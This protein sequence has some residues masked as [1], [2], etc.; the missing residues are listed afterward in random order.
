[1][2]LL[3]IGY[4]MSKDGFRHIWWIKHFNIIWFVSFVHIWSALSILELTSWWCSRYLTTYFGNS[5]CILD[6]LYG[7]CTLLLIE[8]SHWI[9]L[10]HGSLFDFWLGCLPVAIKLAMRMWFVMVFVISGALIKCTSLRNHSSLKLHWYRICIWMILLAS[11]VLEIRF[12]FSVVICKA[13]SWKVY[14]R[15]R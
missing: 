7:L 5:S 10:F 15:L 11:G 13:T 8:I 9:F 4:F 12:E 2:L 1:M 6:Y 14:C 3:M